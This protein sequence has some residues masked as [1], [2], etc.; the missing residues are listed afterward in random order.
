MP[1][2]PLFYKVVGVTVIFVVNYSSLKF[3]L[4][5]NYYSLE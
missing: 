5:S 1:L 2:K 3:Y 4:L